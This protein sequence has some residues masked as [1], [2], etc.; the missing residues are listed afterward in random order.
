VIA[1]GELVLPNRRLH[2]VALHGMSNPYFYYDSDGN[3]LCITNASQCDAT[4]GRSYS[5]TSFDTRFG[6]VTIV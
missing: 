1:L 2:A 6:V 4:A 5:W 3:M